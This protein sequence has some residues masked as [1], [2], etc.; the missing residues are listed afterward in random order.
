MDAI[1]AQIQD[2]FEGEIDFEG[3]RI[4]E[5]ICTCFLSVT[6]AV[7]LAVGFLQKDIYLT[8]WTGLGGTV[9]TMLAVVPPWPAYNK[10]PQSWIGSRDQIRGLPA[11]GIVVDGKKVN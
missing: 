10:H 9:L 1:V 6:A 7:A 2:T 3:Q 5:L 4:S 11:G 8:M